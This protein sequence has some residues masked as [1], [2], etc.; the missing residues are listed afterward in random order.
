MTGQSSRIVWKTTVATN[1]RR[2]L[3][4]I[5]K[6]SEDPIEPLKGRIRL[7][8]A[9]P[10]NIK[11]PKMNKASNRLRVGRRKKRIIRFFLI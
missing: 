7:D 11:S 9:A 8:R 4:E 2:S 10:K 6:A 1:N 3:S 5:A